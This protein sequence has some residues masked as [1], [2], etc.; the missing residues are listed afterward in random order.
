MQVFAQKRLNFFWLIL[1][2]SG[3]LFLSR[4]AGSPQVERHAVRLEREYAGIWHIG[5]KLVVVVGG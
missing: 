4:E 1:V 5:G 3:V 2:K